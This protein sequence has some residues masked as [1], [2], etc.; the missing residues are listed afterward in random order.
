MPLYDFECLDCG[1]VFERTATINQREEVKC[2]C[3]GN[4]GILITNSKSRHWFREHVTEH[5]TGDPLHVKS[6]GHMKQL[7]KDNNVTSR[8]IGDVRNISEI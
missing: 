3:G 2:V 6:L 8:A 4:T 1:N 5:F 7:C